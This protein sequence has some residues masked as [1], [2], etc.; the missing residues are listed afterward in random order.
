M[1]NTYSSASSKWLS[2]M[3]SQEKLYTHSKSFSPYWSQDYIFVL[4]LSSA[5]HQ[6]VLRS[7]E[8]TKAILETNTFIH[9]Y[10]IGLSEK[11]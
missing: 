11:G 8:M 5:L 3:E 6:R 4:V 10:I 2:Y 7:N 1:V 9:N